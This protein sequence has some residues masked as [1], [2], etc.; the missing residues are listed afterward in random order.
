MVSVH[1]YKVRRKPNPHGREKGRRK[2]AGPCGAWRY[3]DAFRWSPKVCDPCT[4]KKAKDLRAL[5]AERMGAKRLPDP[6]KS[7]ADVGPSPALIASA[8]K[9]RA[10]QRAKTAPRRAKDAARKRRA[11]AAT[12]KAVAK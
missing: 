12:K 1:T 3:S 2:C 9:K 5:W 11:R 8:K 7:P 4:E 10:A 6:R